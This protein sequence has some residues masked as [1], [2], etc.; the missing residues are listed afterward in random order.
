[1][2]NINEMIDFFN[3]HNKKNRFEFKKTQAA[4][5]DGIFDAL[6]IVDSQEKHFRTICVDVAGLA[7]VMGVKNV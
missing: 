4:T 2:S 7:K 3:K 6:S 1:M 5:E